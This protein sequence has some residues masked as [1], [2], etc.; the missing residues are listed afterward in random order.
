MSRWIIHA[1]LDAFFASVEQLDKPELRGRPVVV[2]APPQSRGVVAAASYEARPFG[3]RSAMPMAAALR[4]CP[5]AVRVS[6]RFERY[7]EIS[8]RVMDIFRRFTPL[9]EP[10]SLDEA[11]LDVSEGVANG[12]PAE[13]IARAIKECVRQEVGLTV[14]V[15][16]ASSRSVAKI[17]S[18]MGK[19]DGLLIVAPGTERQFLAPLPV[20]SLWGVGP[21]T[22]ERLAAESITTI[23]ELAERSEEWARRLFGEWGVYFLHLAQGIDDSPVVVE[24]ERKSVSSEIT[25]PRDVSDPRALES[26]LRQIARETAER[27]QRHGL[28]GRTVKIKLRLADFTTFTRQITLAQPTDAIDTISGEAARL[29]AREMTS[30]RH[31]RLLGVGVCNFGPEVG[32]ERPALFSLDEPAAR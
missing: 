23:G 19:P 11:F 27:L 13:D 9:V 17:A 1:D 29:L 6:P 24:H 3:V 2:G 16:V 8:R 10:I 20:R 31:F 15:G 18:D 28:K 30:G 26:S 7:S 5:E 22:A 32:E 4:L 14:S 21:K 12:R 25:F